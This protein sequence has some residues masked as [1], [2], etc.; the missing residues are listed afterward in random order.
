MC[1]SV[2]SDGSAVRCGIACKCGH[3]GKIKTCTTCGRTM[4]PRCAKVFENELP[5]KVS[6]VKSD[7][8]ICS[9]CAALPLVVA[10][11]P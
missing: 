6:V 2:D 3:I 9:R 8:T 1:C 5:G 4:C 11:G 10:D 7:R